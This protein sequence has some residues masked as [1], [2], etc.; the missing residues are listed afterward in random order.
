MPPQKLLKAAAA[1][2]VAAL[3]ASASFAATNITVSTAVVGKTPQYVG[4]SMGHYM[5]NSNTGAWVDY[6]FCNAYR[7][8]SAP[9]YY[10]PSDDISPFGDGVNDLASFDSRK[11]ALRNDPL[12][13]SYINWTKWDP[14]FA[15]FQQTGTNHVVLDPALADLYSRGIH[16]LEEISRGTSDPNSTTATNEVIDWAGKW[17]QW[18]HFYAQAFHE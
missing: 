13:T 12:N 15:T 3:W 10:E 9:S 4:F 17:E 18:Q 7:I 11:A 8:W 1:A 16:V 5:P 2:V 6:S 14:R